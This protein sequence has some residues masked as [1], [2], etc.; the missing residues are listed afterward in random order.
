MD[1]IMDNSWIRD[2][3]FQLKLMGK[4]NGHTLQYTI[5]D[6]LIETAP[7]HYACN[8]PPGA[9][10]AIL[11]TPSKY[12][13][14]GVYPTHGSPTCLHTGCEIEYNALAEETSDAHFHSL[15]PHCIRNI[16]A[17]QRTIFLAARFGVATEGAVM[18]S[19]LKP[20]YQCSKAIIAS[21]IKQI[22]YAG[23]VY[24][25]PRT[26]KILDNAN[27]ACEH[28]DVELEYGK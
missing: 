4:N 10:G 15:K 13:F 21:G 2:S 8:R 20:C 22:W 24:D 11:Y 5:M 12:I 14:S 26:R 19:V 6:Y 25:E 28:I 3:N 27:V 16:H 17:E 7:K 23:K 9:A 18:Y 1:K